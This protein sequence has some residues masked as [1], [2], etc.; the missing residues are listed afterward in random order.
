[1]GGKKKEGSIIP[2]LQKD[3]TVLQYLTVKKK[4]KKKPQWTQLYIFIFF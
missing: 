3:Y 2:L 4:L 1:M